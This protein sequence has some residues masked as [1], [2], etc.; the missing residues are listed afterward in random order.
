[1]GDQRLA[2]FTLFGF[3]YKILQDHLSRNIN[4]FDTAKTLFKFCVY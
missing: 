4:I 2:G 1:M 3:I